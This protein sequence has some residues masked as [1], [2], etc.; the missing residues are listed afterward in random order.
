MRTFKV[1]HYRSDLDDTLMCDLGCKHRVTY[2]EVKRLTECPEE[3]FDEFIK[4]LNYNSDGIGK[5][6]VARDYQ[7]RRYLSKPTW[8]GYGP[9]VC[10]DSTDKYGDKK[11]FWN[12]PVVRLDAA[13][14]L[15]GERI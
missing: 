3:A 4:G 10:Q 6:R 15:T 2:H 9:W 12:H 11:S 7:G 1:Y 8:D 14:S 5:V 13:F